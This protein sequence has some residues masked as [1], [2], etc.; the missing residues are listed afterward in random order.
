MFCVTRE[1]IQPSVQIVNLNKDEK[2]LTSGFMLCAWLSPT[3]TTTVLLHA[4]L[5]VLFYEK[6]FN[7][8]RR[9]LEF[10][11]VI[12]PNIVNS[13]QTHYCIANIKTQHNYPSLL[14][15][16]LSPPASKENGNDTV[17]Q[18][19]QSR[20]NHLSFQI[21]RHILICIHS[22]FL[23]CRL[24]LPI[25]DILYTWWADWAWCSL[26]SVLKL[27]LLFRNS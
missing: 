26:S 5:W 18:E 8:S 2:S 13:L 24:L 23:S 22:V 27:F 16:L 20:R 17:L 7:L 12:K 3:S 6:K 11:P 10:S 25:L 1:K 9:K 15:F 14:L 4:F 21:C 19:K